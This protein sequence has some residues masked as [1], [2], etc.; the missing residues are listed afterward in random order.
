[1]F[2]PFDK[3]V[4]RLT[5]TFT[6]RLWRMKS[7]TL[8]ARFSSRS[9]DINIQAV[10]LVGMKLDHLLGG[11]WEED[12]EALVPPYRHKEIWRSLRPD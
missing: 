3:V 12:R 9:K 8:L 5:M 11:R 6:M 7:G 4:G 10:E 1:M 2:L